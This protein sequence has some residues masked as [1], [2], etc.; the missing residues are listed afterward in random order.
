MKKCSY[1]IC[2]ELDRKSV[3]TPKKPLFAMGCLVH[4]IY[5]A[6]KAGVVYVQS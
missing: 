4:V 6:Y 5:G 3:F 1:I 2:S